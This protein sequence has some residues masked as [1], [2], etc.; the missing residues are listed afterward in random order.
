[1]Q[2][3]RFRNIKGLKTKRVTGDASALAVFVAAITVASVLMVLQPLDDL[4][5]P[6]PV[7]QMEVG[8]LA[9]VFVASIPASQPIRDSLNEHVP[10]IF[11]LLRRRVELPTAVRALSLLLVLM[12]SF[13]FA[14]WATADVLGGYNGFGWSFATHPLLSAV[15]DTTGL[16]YIESQYMGNFRAVG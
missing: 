3:D 7:C 8:A 12:G 16:H 2:L 1:V 9:I 13:V 5:L 15:Y 6:S 14:F 11:R 4:A 10:S